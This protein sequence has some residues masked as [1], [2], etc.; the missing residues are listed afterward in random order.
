MYRQTKRQR[1]RE[2]RGETERKRECVFS[3]APVRNLTPYLVLRSLAHPTVKPKFM[4]HINVRI[5]MLKQAPQVGAHK[6]FVCQIYTLLKWSCFILGAL[7]NLIPFH[8]TTNGPNLN[9]PKAPRRS[10][11]VP[12]HAWRPLVQPGLG[13]AGFAGKGVALR[14]FMV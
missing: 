4:Q 12:G 3:A 5:Y 14:G 8:S 9:A 7:L 1:E 10:V 2:R 11:P 13:C 6:N